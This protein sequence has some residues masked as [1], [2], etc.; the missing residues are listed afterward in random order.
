[1]KVIIHSIVASDMGNLCPAP[2]VRDWEYIKEFLDAD[3]TPRIE[4]LA[5]IIGT[6]LE[7]LTSYRGWLVYLS[8]GVS[9]NRTDP[10]TNGGNGYICLPTVN[11]TE[12]GMMTWEGITYLIEAEFVV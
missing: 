7:L 4:S 6:P 5:E 3:T 12:Q 8:G 9:F 2:S 11:V 10:T 1:M